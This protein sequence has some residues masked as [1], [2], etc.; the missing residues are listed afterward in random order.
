MAACTLEYHWYWHVI[1]ALVSLFGGVLVL[2]PVRVIWT[3]TERRRRRRPRS[4]TPNGG[5]RSALGYLRSGAEGI[6]AGNSTA[7]KI[8]VSRIVRE[9]VRNTA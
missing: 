9:N 3:V 8:L 1:A 6:L 2:L 4:T 7:N 5:V